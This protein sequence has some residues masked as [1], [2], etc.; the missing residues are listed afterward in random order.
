MADLA[1]FLVSP[2][3][4]PD[5]ADTGAADQRPFLPMGLAGPG[6]TG[7]DRCLVRDVDRA[8]DSSDVACDLFGAL[9]VEIEQRH[10]RSLCRER[11]R[12]GFAKPRGTAGDHGR[13]RSIDLHYLSFMQT[14][15]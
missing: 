15:A 11:P 14:C 9:L 13:D 8:G 4:L 2:D 10:A 5:R 7:I 1:R 12:T 3:R 6:K